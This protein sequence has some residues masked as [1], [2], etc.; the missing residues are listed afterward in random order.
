[1]AHDESLFPFDKSLFQVCAGQGN[2]R[3]NLDIRGLIA[4]KAGPSMRSSKEDVEGHMSVPLPDR[5]QIRIHFE[6]T[7][8]Q[9]PH[10]L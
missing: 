4:E 8:R 10:R 7:G 6:S 1:M 3:S 5:D 2:E 9:A